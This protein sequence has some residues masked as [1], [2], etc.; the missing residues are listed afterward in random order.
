MYPIGNP[1]ST[2]AF[3][4]FLEGE[5]KNMATIFES[6]SKQA[7]LSSEYLATIKEL[8][9]SGRYDAALIML[10]ILFHFEAGFGMRFND[11]QSLQYGSLVKELSRMEFGR[12]ALQALGFRVVGKSENL[13]SKYTR[14]G[15]NVEKY[16]LQIHANRYAR[17]K[18][19]ICVWPELTSKIVA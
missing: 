18:L 13:G 7:L 12:D 5:I 1:T 10:S 9:E 4:H 14:G 6:T 15:S 19:T 11:A 2:R 17:T 3:P 8:T 16:M